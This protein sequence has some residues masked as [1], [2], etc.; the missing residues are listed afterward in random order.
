MLVE[1]DPRTAAAAGGIASGM[2]SGA[3]APPL[4]LGDPAAGMTHSFQ[5]GDVDFPAAAVDV[6]PPRDAILHFL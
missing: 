2:R 6:R 4:H 3:V 5:T 1:R